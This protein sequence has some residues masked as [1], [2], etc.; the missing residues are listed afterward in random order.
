[1]TRNARTGAVLALVGLLVVT[2]TYALLVVDRPRIESV[3]N[4]WGDVNADRSEVETVIVIDNP[5]LLRVGDAA[6]D[7]EYTVTVN[8]INFTAERREAV[9][10]GGR[11]DVVRT[12]TWL[13]NDR[14]PDW[15]VTHVNNDETSTVTVDPSVVLEYGG[16]RVPAERWTHE[17]TFH[18]DLL[19]PL[20]TDQPRRVSAFGRTVIVVNETEAHWGHATAERTPIDASATVTNALPVALPVTDIEY[21]IRLNGIVVG[22]G[23]AA[24]RTLLPAGETRTLDARASID[25]SRLDEW[26]VTHLRNDETSTLS[27]SFDAT[28]E[29]AGVERRLPLEFISYNRTFHTDVFESN[30]GATT[31]S[32]AV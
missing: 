15:W 8:G 9:R 23:E 5:L 27:I 24:E 31:P 26:W 14:I 7:V 10:L 2:A 13:H 28:V 22:Q 29:F 1:M 17:R 30:R 21:T 6:A 20:Q 25:N 18:T 32:S 11:D 12:S 19:G 16:V 4:E 3:E